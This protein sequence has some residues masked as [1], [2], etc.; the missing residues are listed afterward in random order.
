MLNLLD[1]LRKVIFEDPLDATE[2]GSDIVGLL[3]WLKGLAS[4]RN[5]SS[6][7]V[8]TGCLAVALL[9]SAIAFGASEMDTIALACSA[10]VRL[11]IIGR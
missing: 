6:Y 10:R 2:P 3:A 7:A 8:L 1:Q 11:W 9:F 4:F 5:L